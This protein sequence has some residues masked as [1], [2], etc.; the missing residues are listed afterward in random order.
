MEALYDALPRELQPGNYVLHRA[1]GTTY[2]VKRWNPTAA[3]RFAAVFKHF[4][5][6]DLAKALK[7]LT[8]N[9]VT[10]RIGA[11]FGQT[12]GK[13]SWGPWDK[14]ALE[15][16]KDYKAAEREKAERKRELDRRG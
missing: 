13:L 9:E 1:D 5:S 7:N 14:S 11:K 12:T 4:D 10:D 6:I 16:L 15:Y 3:Q 2:V 8:V